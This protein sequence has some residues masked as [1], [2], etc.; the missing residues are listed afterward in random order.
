[1][2]TCSLSTKAQNGTGRDS[3]DLYVLPY[4]LG[5]GAGQYTYFQNAACTL[6]SPLTNNYSSSPGADKWIKITV[7]NNGDLEIRGGTSNY[8]SVFYLFDCNWNLITSADDGHGS[9]G[10]IGLQPRIQT[11]VTAGT[12]HLIVDGSS[13]SGSSWPASGSVNIQYY[14]Q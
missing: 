12:Y 8:D 1:L 10:P 11:Y 5:F 14:L 13:K 7:A 4:T 2:L 3:T 6:C 9:G